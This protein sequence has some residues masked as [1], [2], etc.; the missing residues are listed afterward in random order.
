MA[1]SNLNEVLQNKNNL[2]NQYN[3]IITQKENELSVFK[4]ERLMIIGE[5]RFINQLLQSQPTN[6]SPSPSAKIPVSQE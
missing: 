1:S 3:N 4:E 5:I 6:E 2:L